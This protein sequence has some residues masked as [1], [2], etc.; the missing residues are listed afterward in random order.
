MNKKQVLRSMF[1][2]SVAATLW[3][4]CSNDE[5]VLD[6]KGENNVEN[7]ITVAFQ[8]GLPGGDEVDYSRA[9]GDV[10]ADDITEWSFKT[11]RV[12]DFKVTGTTED[13]AATLVSIYKVQIK[14][15]SGSETPTVGSGE[16]VPT[17]DGSKYSV[18]LSLRAKKG[19]NHQFVFVAN[20]S[21]SVYDDAITS[22]STLG[23]LMAST[24]DKVL[25][26]GSSNPNTFMGISGDTPVD[27]LTAD[28]AKKAGLAM[29]GKSPVLTITDN[30]ATV[31]D[32][33]NMVRIMAR[34]DVRDYVPASR[35]FKLISVKMTNGAPKGYLFAN[36]KGSIWDDQA[37]Y[38]TLTQNPYY[39]SGYAATT[40]AD[41]WVSSVTSEEGREGTWY[42][43]VLY[44]YEYP[45][46][47]GGNG[48]PEP[49]LLVEYTLNG[50]P[51]TQTVK[52][53]KT[54]ATGTERFDIAR[55]HVYT[56]QIGDTGVEGQPLSFTFLVNDWTAHE[57][58]ADLNE[59]T[60]KN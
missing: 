2:L 35:N 36:M 9:E 30:A 40:G 7:P 19:E 11:L 47:I 50:S 12:Y 58:D 43:K 31:T 57:I 53:E 16:C 39:N 45:Q 32:P 27:K 3:A 1:A 10:L 46:F 23:N 51:Y 41:A 24:A 54:T 14:T 5:M 60:D 4:G 26:N 15:T 13:P 48:T 21:C 42:K 37:A 25:S 22:A 6:N 18:K 59:G 8:L 38:V 17:G 44:A 33:I 56:L 55:N 20:D 34:V 49:S 28:E 52:L 29:T